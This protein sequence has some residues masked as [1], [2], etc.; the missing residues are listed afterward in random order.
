[1]SGDPW[2][3]ENAAE[4]PSA[5]APELSGTMAPFSLRRGS[6]ETVIGHSRLVGEGIWLV[7]TP[8]CSS[9]RSRFWRAS[10]IWKLEKA[11]SFL[12]ELRRR[13]TEKEESEA[14]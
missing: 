7:T 11:T 12:W 8:R 14:C 6:H 5:L 13:E 4:L 9:P 3:I 1:M 10:P 2:R